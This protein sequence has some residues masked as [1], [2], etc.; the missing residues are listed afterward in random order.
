MKPRALARRALLEAQARGLRPP[1]GLR[2][3][4]RRTLER[5]GVMQ[6]APE[7]ESWTAP[8]V[9]GRAMGDPPGPRAGSAPRDA[10]AA[11]SSPRSAAGG[12]TRRCLILTDVLDTGGIDEFVA[13]LARRL[14]EAGW[15]ARVAKTGVPG[16]NLA[17]EL[18]A[19]GVAVHETATPEALGELLDSLRPDVITAHTAPLWALQTARSRG[20]PVVET[21]HGAPTPLATNWREEP[22]R[23]SYVTAFVAV[24]EQVRRHYLAG[25]PTFPADA[26]VAVP[27]GYDP[28]SRPAS[29]R[30]T[31]REWLGIGGEFL[32]TSLGRLSPEKNTYGMVAAFARLA[33]GD[34]TC[35]LLSAGRVDD[36][37]YAHHVARLV[38][39]QPPHVR[40]R[41]HLRDATTKVAAV[42]AAT[43][44]FVMDSFYEGWG[45]ASVEALAAGVPI[46]RSATG[47]AIEQIG[48]QGR[49]GYLVGNP[50][51]DADRV[52]WEAI[53]RSRFSSQANESELVDAMRSVVA[54][55][56]R[57]RA[58][59]PLSRPRRSS[60]S[61]SRSASVATRTC[62]RR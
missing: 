32:F 48:E 57:G 8:L 29:D 12:E 14:P 58:G 25:N 13:L 3:V 60:S 23:S 49:R 62:S 59:E 27:I 28:A 6:G 21:L 50:A 1:A 37:V 51:G 35:H 24:S 52:S 9:A 22:E 5:I 11:A 53:S 36:P 19:D 2:R 47:G 46:I 54:Q 33:S 38:E 10:P 61:R 44:C 20:V 4:S 41:I 42:L 56:T 45:I 16:G 26:V 30:A 18:A 7:L 39:A 31:A 40:R 17:A 15:P 34:P 43:D 55:R